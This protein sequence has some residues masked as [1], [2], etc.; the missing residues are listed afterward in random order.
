MYVPIP[1]LLINVDYWLRTSI[2]Y[3]SYPYGKKLCTHKTSTPRLK[4]ALARP[5]HPWLWKCS[6]SRWVSPAVALTSKIPSSMGTCTK[7]TLGAQC[8]SMGAIPAYFFFWD[9]RHQKSCLQWKVKYKNI[10]AKA[11]SN[12]RSCRLTDDGQVRITF[13]PAIT[14]I[15]LGGL[16][17]K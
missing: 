10:N 9:E 15:I 14:P 4:F 8:Y 16:R 12:S 1:P 13:W 2:L 5:L 17:L 6:P 7:L 11:I 3:T